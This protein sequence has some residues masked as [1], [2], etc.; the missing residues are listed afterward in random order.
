MNVSV[1]SQ[2]KGMAILKITVP[3]EVLTKA[4][5]EAYNVFA[6]NHKDFDVP[7]SE[8]TT[9]ADCADIYRQA[10]QDVFSDLYAEALKASG[11]TIASEPVIS[12]IQASETEGVEYQ[13][14]FALRPEIKLGQYKGIHVKMPVVEPTEEE[15][16]SAMQHAAQQNAIPTTVDRPAELGDIATIDFTGYLDG[17]PF[18]GGQGNDY[19][20]TLGSGSFIPGFEEQLVGASAGDNVMVNVTFPEN[21][22]AP[23]LAGKPTVFRCKVKKVEAM[24]IQPLSAEQEAEIRQQVQQQKKAMADQQIEDEVL[25]RILEEAEVEIPSAMVDSEVSIVMNQFVA[26]IGQQGMDL[27]T[28]QQRTGKTTEEMLAEM[29]P[30]ATR[31]IMLRL[32]LS[33]IAEEEKIT[34]TQEEVEKQWEQMAQQYG[35]DV[36]RLK[37]YMG[38]A[39]EEEIKAEI[40]NAKAYALL[41]SA[42]ILEMN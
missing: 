30:L 15:Y 23:N 3:G 7:R 20:L 34:V 26:E 1:L 36:P 39:A 6:K 2:E 33:A 37:V 38:E 35:I 29:R 21:Y 40:T 11:L 17:V 13:M 24:D 10:V 19:P 18:D 31:R 12:V 8:V 41:R 42:T 22:H 32:V 27:D 14:E 16:A 25:G 9:S 4:L 28:F 5:D